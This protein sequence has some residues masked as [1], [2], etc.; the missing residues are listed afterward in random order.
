MGNIMSQEDRL[1][2]LSAQWRSRRADVDISP[3]Q[4]WGRLTRIHELFLAAVSKVL[5]EHELNFKEYQTLGAIVLAGDGEVSPVEIAKHNLLTSGGVTNLLSRMEKEGLIKR[6]PHPEDRRSVLVRSTPRGDADF[7]AAIVSE[8]MVEHRL[9]SALT[10]EERQIL[11][12]L[13][14]KLLLSIDPV[15]V[16]A[17][18]F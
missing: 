17:E 18:K 14:R 3:W 1:D 13:L 12:T 10:M 8:N 9:L 6:R 7:D 4:V 15:E 5:G 16:E 11:A 2:Y